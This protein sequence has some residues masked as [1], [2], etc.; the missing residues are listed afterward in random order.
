MMRTRTQLFC[1]LGRFIMDFLGAVDRMNCV[2]VPLVFLT[3]ALSQLPPAPLLGPPA[4]AH[5]R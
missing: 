4:L 1:A 3:Y 5:I 2:E